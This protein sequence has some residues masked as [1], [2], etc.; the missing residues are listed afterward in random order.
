MWTKRITHGEVKELP[1]VFGQRW[2]QH[3]RCSDKQEAPLCASPHQDDPQ[4]K[5]FV[6]P[7][8]GMDVFQN[9]RLWTAQ[10]CCA[11]VKALQGT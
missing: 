8:V 3:L 10:L 5:T 6:H 11:C 4:A 1:H 9:S 7:D 2:N